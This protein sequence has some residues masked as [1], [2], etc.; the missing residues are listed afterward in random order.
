MTK[1]VDE[2]VTLEWC[3]CGI[4]IVA[5]KVESDHKEHFKTS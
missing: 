3:R 4:A 1:R 2:G 5:P